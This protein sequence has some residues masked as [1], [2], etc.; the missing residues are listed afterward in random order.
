VLGRAGGDDLRPPEVIRR[1]DVELGAQPAGHVADDRPGARAID[2]GDQREAGEP[3]DHRLA[4]VGGDRVREV[5]DDLAPPPHRA[6]G[7]DPAGG[8]VGLEVMCERGGVVLGV[9]E[10][11]LRALEPA[12]L[13]RLQ[14]LLLADLAE[15]GQ[16]AD[17]AAPAHRGD[18]IEIRGPQ[19]GEDLARALHADLG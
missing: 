6:A 2:A 18:R 9:D 13:D 11:H 19:R 14:D 10:D 17:R 4:I 15:A 7:R 1:R 3:R 5:I 16:L 8:R 12:V